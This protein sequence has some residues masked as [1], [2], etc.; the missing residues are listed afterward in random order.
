[1]TGTERRDLLLNFLRNS[2]VPISGSELAKELQVSR[3][4]IVQDIAVIRASGHEVFSTYQG[5]LLKENPV[6]MR[7]FKQN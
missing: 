4:V 6:H 1:M 2:T 3:Q 5:Y 7:A